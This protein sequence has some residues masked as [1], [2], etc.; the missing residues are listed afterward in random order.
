MLVNSIGMGFIARSR[1]V[2][3]GKQQSD[4]PMGFVFLAMRYLPNGWKV[5]FAASSLAGL[6]VICITALNHQL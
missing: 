6:L 3:L 1:Q 2:Q 5:W 4:P